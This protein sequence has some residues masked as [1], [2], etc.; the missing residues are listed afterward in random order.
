MTAGSDASRVNELMQEGIRYVRDNQMNEAYRV[1]REVVNRDPNNEYAWIWVSQTST[2]R[3]EKREAIDRAF[4]INPNSQHAR[5]ALARLEQEEAVAAP[6][7]PTFRPNSIGGEEAPGRSGGAMR[8][9]PQPLNDP[10]DLRAAMGGD[11]GG[12]SKKGRDKKTKRV[13]TT[14]IGSPP[15]QRPR[16]RSS[17]LRLILLL[18]II[19]VIGGGIVYYL[20][21]RQ[22]TTVSEV[23]SPPAETT[24]PV[25][26]AG[27]TTPGLENTTAAPGTTSAATAE[28]GTTAAAT[29][30]T[31]GAATPAA[32][33]DN[34]NVGL[35]PTPTPLSG[36][37]TPA[38]PSGV[39][40]PTAAASTTAG[41]TTAASSTTAASA[42]TSAATGSTPAASTTSP[43]SVPGTNAQPATGD[44]VN[45]AQQLISSG[46][47]K[48][49]ITL[50]NDV[51]KNDPRNVTANLR[52]GAA[53]L[54]APADQLTSGVNRY[55]EA[56]KSFRQVTELA[57]TWPGGFARL[58]ETYAAKGDV[59]AAIAAFTRSLELDPNGPERWLA[60]ASLYDRNNQPAEAAYARSRAQ[61]L[62]PT[63]AGNSAAPAPT[64]TVTR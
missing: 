50:L 3:R 20:L 26:V 11:D 58:G 2:D 48:A 59:P 36:A 43:A 37:A 44:P 33:V 49:A 9:N 8:F 45:Q 60:L 22:T 42:T 17:P 40:S 47:Y 10:N 6:V 4:A 41:A 46:N 19:L 24:A 12:R 52:L 31:S 30:G 38:S 27:S 61:G 21:G 7:A 51:I 16:R 1:F 14:Q 54:A 53:Y 57:P 55:D 32:T 39:G 62:N 5:Q 64:P 13:A 29:G 23:T 18:L 35:V 63:P 25:A 34:S 28:T 15:P 56:L